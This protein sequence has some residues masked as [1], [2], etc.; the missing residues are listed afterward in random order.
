MLGHTDVLRMEDR[1]EFLKRMHN[2]VLSR[3]EGGE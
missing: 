2:A 3:I 1:V